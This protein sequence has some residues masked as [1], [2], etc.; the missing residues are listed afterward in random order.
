MV[1]PPRHLIAVQGPTDPSA[2]Y[3]WLTWD[4]NDPSVTAYDVYRDGSLLAAVN[5]TGDT[6]NKCAYK[7][8]SVSGSRAYRYKIRARN[9]AGEVS[10]PSPAFDIY[11]RT[12]ADLGPVVNVDDQ[13]GTTDRDKI[14]AAIAAAKANGGGVVKFG[15][16]LTTPKVYS[17]ASGVDRV[18]LDRSRNVVLRGGGMGATIL[19]DSGGSSTNVADYP[20]LEVVGNEVS[21][22]QISTAA[23]A[24]G[25]RV[26][27]VTSTTG[28]L[29]GHRIMFDQTKT[30]TGAQLATTA[31][32]IQDPGTGADNTHAYDINV[33]ESIV[34]TTVTFKWPFSQ[35][36][37][38]AVTWVAMAKSGTTQFFNNGVERMTIEGPAGNTLNRTLLQVNDT[39][40]CYVAE[41]RFSEP[42]RNHIE[43]YD[44]YGL[45]VVG[46]EFPRMGSEMSSGSIRYGINGREAVQLRVVACDFGTSGTLLGRSHI[47]LSEAQRAVVRHS[48]F[49][50]SNTYAFNEHGHGSRHWRFENNYVNTPSASHAGL[51]F[52][53]ETFN[54]SGP[55]MVRN[56]RFEACSYDARIIEN[57][58]EIRFLDIVSA[59]C[60]KSLTRLS[61]WGD[62]AS[63]PT[64]M[65]AANFGSLRAT[66][67][68]WTVTGAAAGFILGD[69]YSI[70][71][72]PYVGVKDVI[73][74]ECSIGSTGAAIDFRGDSTKTNRFQV[75]NNTGTN[76]YLRPAF[77]TGDYW[78]GNADGISYGSPTEVSWDDES[79]AWE[80]YDTATSA[81]GSASV[82]AV[83][84]VTVVGTVKASSVTR[85]PTSDSVVVTGWLDPVN[86]YTDDALEASARPA[87]GST[88]STDW[89]GF[90]F[91]T[92]LPANAV[93]GSVTVAVTWRVGRNPAEADM[94]A[95][96]Y[97]KG[98]AKGT[99]LKF[100]PADGE[101]EVTRSFTISGLARADLL[102]ANFAVR[103]RATRSGLD[104][105]GYL[106]V[107]RV[108]VAYSL[109][110]GV[111]VVVSGGGIVAVTGRRVSTGVKVLVSGEGLISI[112][113]RKR[114]IGKITVLSPG[115]V[116]ARG[117]RPTTLGE[118]HVSGDGDVVVTN[119]KQAIGQ[120]R[121]VG[122][123][124][125]TVRAS[126][127]LIG[128]A[129][130]TGPGVVSVRGSKRVSG[131][132]TVTGEGVV[133]LGPA[134]PIFPDA[135]IAP[136]ISRTNFI[137]TGP[138]SALSPVSG[139]EVRVLLGVVH[140]EGDTELTEVGVFGL[141][142][143]DSNESGG[144]VRLDLRGL[145]RS[146]KIQRDRFR[147]PYVIPAGT[148]YVEAIKALV[149]RSL[150]GTVFREEPTDHTTPL[151]QWEFGD[152]PLQAIAEMAESI[153]YEAF[154]A[155]DG[156]FVLRAAAIVVDDPVW[157]FVEG[158]GTVVDSLGRGLTREGV[159]N[160][161][162]QRGENRT[163]D[164]PPVQAEAWDTDP[165]S[166]TYYDPAN[167][168]SSRFGA[169][170]IFHV[171][172]YLTTTQQA[173][174]AA[175]ARLRTL[176]GLSEQVSITARQVPGL[177]GGDVVRAT[178]GRLNLDAV[179]V[180]ERLTLPLRAGLM[181]VK[182]RERRL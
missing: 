56:I 31:G 67:R 145:D 33:I 23:I 159:Y 124:T 165:T 53:N 118:A 19:R 61:G 80:A 137:P 40:D 24:V 84:T 78:R 102:D 170:P 158:P 177:E 103:V 20:L 109:P 113:P 172:E 105:R 26:V 144:G 171:S 175:V 91:D 12:D 146:V 36:F 127:V 3:V 114:A 71:N 70:S 176:R 138:E 167:P 101:A 161:V 134:T 1:L 81:S 60:A 48:R 69:S 157:E 98:S 92:R 135:P 111:S 181:S 77:V 99:E 182:A 178:R 180:I 76:N 39:V 17:W 7:D 54:F 66:F 47:T 73:I 52:G 41:V 86:A 150:P 46:C 123:G 119:R 128:Q 141:E 90:G 13:T 43:T 169:V 2:L 160:G 83:G 179:Y 35:Q 89:R 11:V 15:G 5:V 63:T 82:S 93:I 112:A 130:V 168:G 87:S 129:R 132:A 155:G 55:G 110:A 95:Q 125:A 163:S 156:S 96:V 115:V 28:L 136:A 151:L 65:S 108:T 18:R 64:Q 49:Y 38:A 94:G 104:W 25:D 85:T 147:E 16:T 72:F 100:D 116:S 21:I 44:A 97:V 148:N 30:G 58:Y 126:V 162:V 57:S 29:V 37:T 140:P 68:R 9:A 117:G 22:G 153:G 106:D 45:T 173:H 32:A 120:A 131:S 8:T 133:V 75:T 42:N 4:R 88:I 79:F 14:L 149:R 62:D 122:E 107:I 59:N 152:D 34:G 51:L 121:V 10:G 27:S 74:D 174:D 6:W 154:F 164:L 50:D 142:S 143:T 166:P 139:T